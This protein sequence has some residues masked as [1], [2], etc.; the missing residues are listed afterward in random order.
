MVCRLKA[1][2]LESE[3]ASIAKQRLVKTSGR[4]NKL[5]YTIADQ[6]SVNTA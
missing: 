3:R 5:E 6:R 1:E 4:D 2:Y